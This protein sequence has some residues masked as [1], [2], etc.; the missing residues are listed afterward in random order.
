MSN[1]E[2]LFKQMQHHPL[3]WRMAQLQT[4]AR[5]FCLSENRPGGGSSHVTFRASNGSKVTVP[6]HRPVKPVYVRQFVNMI[7]QLEEK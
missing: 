7:A 5:H 6:D 2:K 1:A 3:N 4:V